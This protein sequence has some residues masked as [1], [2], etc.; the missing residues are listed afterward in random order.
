[1]PY[2]G[3][4]TYTLP[5]GTTK[6][7]GDTLT[8]SLWNTAFNDLAEA[9][10]EAR[11]IVAGGTGADTEA[12]ARTSLGIGLDEITT[13]TA[14]NSVGTYDVTGLDDY[15]EIEIFSP[16]IAMS[17]AQQ[18]LLRLGTGAGPTFATGGSDYVTATIGEGITG[19]DANAASSIA[20]SQS[21]TSVRIYTRLAGFNKDTTTSVNGWSM[22]AS[23]VQMRAGLRAVSE[24]HTAIRI[25]ISSGTFSSGTFAI[26]GRK[27]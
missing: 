9:N 13:I 18:V 17:S 15:S 1:M 24:V 4:G 7:D 21:L 20:L 23:E 3:G 12:G 27:G 22:N 5:A 6:A 2:S 14:D 19:G 16:V 10:N 26:Y 11:P 8:A 25:F